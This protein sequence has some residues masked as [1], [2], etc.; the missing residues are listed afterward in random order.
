[1]PSYTIELDDI[2]AAKAAMLASYYKISVEQLLREAAI[3]G[4]EGR[5]IRMQYEMADPLGQKDT[6]RGFL[7]RVHG[8]DWWKW[9][10]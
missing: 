10:R 8:E 7:W 9:Q 6:S 5:E 4:L 2:A 1:M 3:Q